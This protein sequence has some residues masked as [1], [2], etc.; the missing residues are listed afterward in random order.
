MMLVETFTASASQ[1]Q[2]YAPFLSARF[3]IFTPP[4]EDVIE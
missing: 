4:L 2:R 3:L 1:L